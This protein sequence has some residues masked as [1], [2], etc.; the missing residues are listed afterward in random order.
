MNFTRLS[1][2][3]L[4]EKI[5]GRPIAA[6]TRHF[7]K[8]SAFYSIANVLPR[9]MGY[10]IWPLIAML[11]APDGYAIFSN[12]NSAIAV[13]ILIV[14]LQVELPVARYYYEGK[15]DFP[16][17]L[18]TQ[19]FFTTILALVMSAQIWIFRDFWAHTLRVPVPVLMLALV[20]SL[21]Q[22]TQTVYFQILLARKRSL[23]YLN[24]NLAQQ[25]L[26]VMLVALLLPAFFLCKVEGPYRY[27]ALV[28]S[29]LLAYLPLGLLFLFF[30]ARMMRPVFRPDHLRYALHLTLPGLGGA[31][32]MAGLNYFDRVY[33]S[34]HSL[35]LAGQ[36]AF[37][38][39]L[40]MMIRMASSGIF[41]AYMPRFYE[42][43]KEE[44]YGDLQKMFVQ[45]FKLL[46]LGAVALILLSRPVAA[47]IG[48]RNRDYLGSMPIV[49]IIVTS[50]IFM[51]M[52]QCY[53]LYTSFRR[54]YLVAQSLTLVVAG[55][56]NIALNVWLLPLFNFDTRV[57][58]LNTIIPPGGAVPAGLPDRAGV[59]QGAHGELAGR[60]AP[61]CR[62]SRLR[63]AVELLR[64][65]IRIHRDAD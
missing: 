8:D 15:A 44:R 22:I 43:R 39:Q 47:L 56:L 35:N 25:I 61:L 21:A 20:T 65:L 27:L 59:A 55:V 53:G 48:H 49:P 7:L 50:Y 2:F 6:G 28:L 18:G 9:A 33:I 29:N 45:N 36:Y 40:G 5:T 11:V 26:Y 60:A 58:A 19:F 4:A 51:W 24:Y 32:A 37:A 38:Y 62:L 23:S 31:L 14:S 34:S 63:R 16:D 12:Y 10:A 52:G 46:L 3:A 1:P 13:L 17:F 30:L 41:N 54:R 64:L 57:A 42:C